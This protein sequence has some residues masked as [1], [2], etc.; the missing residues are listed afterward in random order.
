MKHPTLN[1]KHQKSWN[2]SASSFSATCLQPLPYS[3]PLCLFPPPMIA[4]TFHLSFYQYT[5]TCLNFH[6]SAQTCAALCFCVFST[7]HWTPFTSPMASEAEGFPK[8][9]DQVDG[10]T[11]TGSTVDTTIQ[12]V[13][14]YCVP[15]SLS[16][17]FFWFFHFFL[18]LSLHFPHLIY[19]KAFRT[20]MVSWV[21]VIWVL[22]VCS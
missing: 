17:L 8:D 14:L 4:S 7:D 19:V 16:S 13:Q 11:T 5:E 6:C 1:I 22:S 21:Q 3:L 2:M 15:T 9:N 10:I 18:Y 20:K 12:K